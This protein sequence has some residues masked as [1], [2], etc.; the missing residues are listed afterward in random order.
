MEKWYVELNRFHIKYEP[1]A[2]IKGQVL[3][4]FIAEFSDDTVAEAALPAPPIKG[5]KIVP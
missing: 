1:W 5:K 2:T 3:A 4:D